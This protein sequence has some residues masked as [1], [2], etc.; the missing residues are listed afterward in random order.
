MHCILRRQ[1]GR[2]TN[3]AVKVSATD[4]WV[5]S[6]TYP[7]QGGW[8]GLHSNC[9]TSYRGQVGNQYRIIRLLC[10]DA[11]TSIVLDGVLKKTWGQSIIRQPQAKPL[12]CASWLFPCKP[13]V[14]PSP[15]PCP[16]MPIFY[17]YR[18]P[19]P[20]TWSHSAEKNRSIPALLRPPTMPLI[21]LDVLAL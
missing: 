14:S 6:A 7:P 9:Q 8:K 2:S 18:L 5:R 3:L 17:V 20:M 10:G 1:S 4:R 21:L 13:L 19:V 12:R 11:P 15:R 16:R